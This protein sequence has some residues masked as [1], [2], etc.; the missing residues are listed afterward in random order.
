MT[1][2]SMDDDLHAEGE[3]EDEYHPGTAARLARKRA[4]G[5]AIIRDEE[6]RLLFVE[7]TYRPYLEIPGGA[8]EENESPRFAC[9]RELREEL[10]LCIHVGRLLVVDW[11]PIHGVWADGLM[12]VFDGGILS[13]DLMA[14]IEL[15][16]TELAGFRLLHLQ[17]AAVR[18]K[19]SMV[20][21][22]AAALD[23]LKGKETMYLEFGRRP[24]RCEVGMT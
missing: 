4:A 6:S 3:P 10:G 19:P 23:A 15:P 8:V 14:S 9:E 21:R 7:P 12:F 1:G 16:A 13:P 20:R 24:D 2:M 17:Q 11:V 18:L 22:L 5:G